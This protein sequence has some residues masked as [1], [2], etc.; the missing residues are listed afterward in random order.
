MRGEDSGD[1][2]PRRLDELIFIRRCFHW[3]ITILIHRCLFV[4]TFLLT[5]TF[6]TLPFSGLGGWSGW[7]CTRG[8]TEDGLLK[9][10]RDGSWGS[11]FGRNVSATEFSNDI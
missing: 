11:I 10:R 7:K 4:V 3:H 9:I 5:C 2:P 6:Q 1:F 8:T